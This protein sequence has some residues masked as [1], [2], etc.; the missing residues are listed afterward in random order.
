MGADQV[1]GTA[2]KQRLAEL[3][4]SGEEADAS[5][6]N[7][8]PL[9]EFATDYFQKNFRIK[10]GVPDSSECETDPGNGNKVQ[11]ERQALANDA[12]VLTAVDIF[13]GEVGDIRV[14]PRFRKPINESDPPA[15]DDNPAKT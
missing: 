7:I 5:V 9:T 8:T 2:G 12:L 15:G 1:I 11:K 10:F 6:E 14:G 13:N 4:L 3:I